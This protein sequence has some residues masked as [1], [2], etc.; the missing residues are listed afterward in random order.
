MRLR[1]IYSV[2]ISLGIKIFNGRLIMGEDTYS[3]K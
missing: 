1:G 2:G 3:H